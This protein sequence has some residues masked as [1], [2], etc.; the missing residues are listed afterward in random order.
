MLVV[1]IMALAVVGGALLSAF[2]EVVFDK[3]ASP[4]VVNFIRWKKPDKLLQKMR[5]QLLV[6]KVV[7]ADAE[8]RQ[9][10]DSNVKRVARSSQ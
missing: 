10:T 7:L 8:K 4:E 3:L 5:S 1:E 9:I 2:I 6:V